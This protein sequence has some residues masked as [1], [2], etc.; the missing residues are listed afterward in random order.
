MR[1]R[2]HA[3]RRPHPPLALAA[4]AARRRRRGGGVAGA[5]R[6]GVAPLAP[7][8]ICR[9]PPPPTGRGR[10]VSAA[11]CRPAAWRVA[12]GCA[13]AT[14]GCGVGAAPADARR[15]RR[16]RGSGVRRPR[17][18]ARVHGRARR[19][20]VSTGGRR[21]TAGAA[22]AGRSRRTV[23]GGGAHPGRRCWCTYACEHGR[24]G[25]GLDWPPRVRG[26]AVTASPSAAGRAPAAAARGGAAPASVGA[27][28]DARRWGC[29]CLRVFLRCV[30]S[31]RPVRARRA[32]SPYGNRCRIKP[33]YPRI[34]GL[35]PQ[36]R[37]SHRWCCVLT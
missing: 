10:P 6:V 3:V 22:A 20:G 8:P 18:A 12:A 15:G 27:P 24:C 17:P 21:W 19:G 23:G 26:L 33:G 5:P 28:A 2:C 34:W 11:A 14:G 32:P 31:R 37:S 13:S 30:C 7:P 25:R 16:G 36:E 1:G 29:A 35:L 4:T 9:G